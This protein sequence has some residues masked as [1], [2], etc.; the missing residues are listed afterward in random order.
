[1]N[2][3]LVRQSVS[4][5]SGD[6]DDTGR[7]CCRSKFEGTYSN[8]NGSIMLEVSRVEGFLTIMGETAE[9]SLHRRRQSTDRRL[10]GRQDCFHTTR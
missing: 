1:M 7:H 6:S 8:A 4:L 3:M 2:H 5:V 9:C 10:Q